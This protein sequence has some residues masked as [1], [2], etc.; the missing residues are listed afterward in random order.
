MN[1]SL[2]EINRFRRRHNETRCRRENSIIRPTLNERME[3]P[4]GFPRTLSALCHK[5][6]SGHFI[7]PHKFPKILINL[8]GNKLLRLLQFYQ[9]DSR[10]LDDLGMRN[11]LAKHVGVRPIVR[12]RF[13]GK[14]DN[15]TPKSEV[16]VAAQNLTPT[17]IVSRN[18]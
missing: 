18:I 6:P 5:T 4:T 2:Q 13:F 14:H 3:S 7:S 9:L 8:L 15:L 17:S 10:G 12:E 1:K 11:S 16:I